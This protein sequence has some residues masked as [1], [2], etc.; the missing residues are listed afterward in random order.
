MKLKEIKKSHFFLLT[1]TLK[2]IYLLYT[3]NII[4]IRSILCLINE[5]YLNSVCME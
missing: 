2:F 4:I 1:L 3:N 5:E